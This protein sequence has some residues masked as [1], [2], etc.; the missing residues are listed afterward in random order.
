MSLTREP[1]FYEQT[2]EKKKKKKNQRAKLRIKIK[3]P[4]FHEH[5]QYVQPRSFNQYWGKDMSDALKNTKIL[6]RY[7]GMHL[8]TKATI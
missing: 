5:E 3:K 6:L 1:K 2:H 8:K 7:L 4:R